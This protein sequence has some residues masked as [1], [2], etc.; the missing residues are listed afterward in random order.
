MIRYIHTFDPKKKKKVVCGT[1]DGYV[2]TKKVSNKHYMINESGYGIQEDAIKHL[3]ELE[4]KRIKIIT[5]KGN[6]YIFSFETILAMPIKDYGHGKQR[7]LN[8]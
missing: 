7:F 5:Q 6:T 3:I 1:Y 8:V 2:F 4:C